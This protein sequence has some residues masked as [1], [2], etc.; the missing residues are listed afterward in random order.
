MGFWK[1]VGGAVTGALSGGPVGAAIGF[2]AG[3]LSGDNTSETT[4]TNRSTR[5]VDLSRMTGD[6][7]RQHGVSSA[8]LLDASRGMSTEEIDASRQRNYDALFG[9]ASGEIN[10]NFAT[11]G[12]RNTAS[13]A[14]RGA[15]VS[16]AGLDRQD[17]RDAAQGRELGRASQ[18]ATIGAEELLLA[19]RADRRAS[20]EAYQRQL[21][22]IWQKRLSTSKITTNSTGTGTSTSPDTFWQSAAAMAGNAVTDDESYLNTG[23]KDLFGGV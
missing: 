22:S 4:S 11:L 21:D 7:S 2:G 5:E 9:R 15:K 10:Q 18:E 6:Q 12:A 3:L 20:A 16:S 1:G 14:R 23:F 17:Q 13:D 19:E 8:G